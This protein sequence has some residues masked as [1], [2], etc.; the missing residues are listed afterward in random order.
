MCVS[1]YVCIC[2]RPRR[3]R[4]GGGRREIQEDGRSGDEGEEEEREDARRRGGEDDRDAVAFLYSE[5]V[6]TGLS[7]YSGVPFRYSSGGTPSYVPRTRF[8]VSF[9]FFPP[10]LRT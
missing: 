1:M 3:E 6:R 7:L 5:I 9:A 10:I 4:D 8:L 2:L